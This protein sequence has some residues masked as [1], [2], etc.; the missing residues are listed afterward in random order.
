MRL[1]T[2]LPGQAGRGQAL[3]DAD[4]F[5]MW[6]QRTDFIYG[7]SWSWFPFRTD[8]ELNWDHM[9]LALPTKPSTVPSVSV[10]PDFHSCQNIYP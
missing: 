8:V 7:F 2:S 4:H 6:I 1:L 10:A 5:L 3:I 9:R